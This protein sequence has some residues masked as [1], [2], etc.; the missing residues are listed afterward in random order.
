MTS[1]IICGLIASLFLLFSHAAWG[2]ATPYT[3]PLR[4]D[5]LGNGVEMPPLEFEYDASQ[6]NSNSLLLG[7]RIRVDGRTFFAALLP[8][9]RLDQ[10]LSQ[11]LTQAQK[12]DWV[13]LLSWPD[14][15]F[16]DAILEVVSKTGRVLWSQEIK[17]PQRDAWKKQLNRFRNQ[18][19][20]SVKREVIDKKILFRTSY[21][22]TN[23]RTA[24]PQFFQLNEWVKFCL[25]KKDEIGQSRLCTAYYEVSQKD[26]GPELRA[27][28]LSPQ[29]PRIILNNEEAP[30]Q[31]LVPIETDKP[32]QFYAELATGVSYEFFTVPERFRLVEMVA[33][34]QEGRARLM[35]EGRTPLQES[36]RIYAEVKPS[37]LTKLFGWEQTIGDFREFWESD[38]NLAQPYILIRGNAGGVFKQ[39]FEITKLPKEGDRVFLHEETIQ[40]TYI[41]NAKV[42]G[43]KQKNQ[44]LKTDSNSVDQA[45][46]KSPNEFTWYFG[47]TQRGV[48]NKSY[49][50]VESGSESY[51]TFHEIYKGYPRELSARLSGIAGSEGNF[52]AMGEVAF[53]YWFEDL[54]GWT[55]Y[56]LAR[57]RWG[58]SA[59]TFMSLTDVKLKT[60][61][62]KL[63]Q[64]T[65]E[66]RYRL[67]PG[68]WGRDET[69]GLLVGFQN[70]IYEN[71]NANFLGGGIF[72]ARSMP[73]VFDD[74]FNVLPMMRYPKWVDLEV[75]YYP[76]SMKADNKPT[77]GGI[78]AVNFHGKVMWSDRWFGEAGF[79][80]K[81]FGFNRT[82]YDDDGLFNRA[83][84]RFAAVYATMGL[85][86][87]F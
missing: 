84:L 39:R 81:Y 11:K 21:G 18:I 22:F 42:F 29:P 2:K 82:F 64:T 79:G 43:V 49:L 48:Y 85:G 16:D 40:G 44:I 58:V 14:F 33:L 55:H 35:A 10:D 66:L 19:G 59:K 56:Y 71:F 83:N 54:M 34:K 74:M 86:L 31:S 12:T 50:T 15:L 65:A 28:L 47:A 63:S 67:T 5:V 60:V 24:A 68:L 62:S 6:S 52:V 9:S 30:I 20:K 87:N 61:T 4:F 75:I 80:M 7:G 69:W 73:R 36:K 38:L 72:W 76:I 27:L 32:V 37:Y 41:D 45:D 51:R 13:F 3:I 23:A 57:Q 26:K 70:V 46:K 53:N 8:L 1:R 77:G 25:M 17:E 78:L